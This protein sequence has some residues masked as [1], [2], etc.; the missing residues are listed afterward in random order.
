MNS[1]LVA[2]GAANRARN[3]G[4]SRGTAQP[5]IHISVSGIQFDVPTPPPTSGDDTEKAI[6]FRQIRDAISGRCTASKDK[7]QALIQAFGIVATTQLQQVTTALQPLLDQDSTTGLIPNVSD[8]GVYR[9]NEA[10]VLDVQGR[11]ITFPG[12][13][14]QHLRNRR[15]VVWIEFNISV[16]PAA[17]VANYTGH[18]M[19]LDVAIKAP[20]EMVNGHMQLSAYIMAAARC[21]FMREMRWCTHVFHSCVARSML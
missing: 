15:N 9:I 2:R 18:V 14:Q 1:N 7:T 4:T 19:P 20:R 3:A 16:N 11:S 6:K 21:S 17:A 13:A 10:R 12:T 5:T 8:P